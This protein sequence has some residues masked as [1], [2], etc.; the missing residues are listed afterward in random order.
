MYETGCETQPAIDRVLVEE[1]VFVVKPVSYPF[2]N[3]RHLKGM[4]KAVPKEVRL[5]AREDLGLALGA[6]GKLGQCMTLP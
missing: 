5:V 3:L 2:R 6:S 1:G 4:S